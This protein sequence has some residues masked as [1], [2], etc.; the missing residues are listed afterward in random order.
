M[1]LI[2]KIT[3]EEAKKINDIEE[4]IKTLQKMRTA[5]KKLIGQC[6]GKGPVGECPII[7]TFSSS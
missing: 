2:S 7:D 6:K 3:A 4:K 1:G 5:L